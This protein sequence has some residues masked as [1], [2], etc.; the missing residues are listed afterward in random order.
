MVVRFATALHFLNKYKSR[1][2]HENVP[3]FIKK[4]KPR[5]FLIVQLHYDI[6]HNIVITH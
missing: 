1:N 5:I 6:F 3:A 4:M 2:T